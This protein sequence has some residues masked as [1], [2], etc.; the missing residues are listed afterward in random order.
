TAAKRGPGAIVIFD[1]AINTVSTDQKFIHRELPRAIGYLQRF[2][3]D[4]IKIDKSFV[5]ALGRSGNGSVIVQR[6]AAR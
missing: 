5:A 3:L 6:S 4:K 1:L 2:P